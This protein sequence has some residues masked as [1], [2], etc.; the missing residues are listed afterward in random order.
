MTCRQDLT[1]HQLLIDPLTRLVMA[2]D[3]VEDKDLWALAAKVAA[4]RHRPNPSGQLDR[5]YR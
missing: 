1:L 2:S 4:R 5:C 3:G